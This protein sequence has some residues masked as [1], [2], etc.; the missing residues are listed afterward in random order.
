M[1]R[2]D[3]K[4]KVSVCLPTYNGARFIHSAIESVLNQSFADFELI[5]CDD[6]ST[7]STLELVCGIHDERLHVYRN[8]DRLGLVGNWNRCLEL[9]SGDYVVLMH[10]DDLMHVNN[11]AHK[12]ALLDG[13][14]AVGFVYSN[15]RRID[16]SGSVIGGHWLP[17]AETDLIEPGMECFQRLVL[18]RKV[19]GESS[20]LSQF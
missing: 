10:Q 19:R 16:E 18:Q 14:P 5:V 12:V 20:K 4:V 11:L 9:I 13:Y 2:D 15:I 8:S 6:A 7:D 1:E 3:P 17:Q